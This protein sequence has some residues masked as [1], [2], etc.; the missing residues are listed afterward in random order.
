MFLLLHHLKELYTNINIRAS[1]FFDLLYQETCTHLN[2][3]DVA[4]ED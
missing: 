4:M 3:I 1:L 2:S